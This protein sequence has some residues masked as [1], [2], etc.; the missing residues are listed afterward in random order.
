M[1]KEKPKKQLSKVGKRI[2]IVDDNRAYASALKCALTQE[3]FELDIAKDGMEAV[4]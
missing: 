1:V 2:L 3:G 4:E